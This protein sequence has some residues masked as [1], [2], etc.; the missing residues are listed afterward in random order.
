MFEKMF[1]PIKIKGLELKHRVVMPAM[2]T[3]FSGNDSYVTPQLIEYHKARVKGG[4]ALNIVEVSSVHTPSA[5]RHF[6]SISEDKYIP[7][8][9]QLT[10]AIHAEGGKAGIQLWQ[11]SLAVGMDQTAQILMASDMPMGP[12]ITLPGITEAQIYEIID[13]YGKAAKRAVEAGFDTVEFHCAHNYLPHSF[14]SGGINHR[15]DEWGGSLENRMKFPLACIKAIRENIPEDMPLFMRV[16]AHDDYLP[17]GMTIEDTIVF[18]N[19]AKEAG[20]DVLDVSRGNII[21]PA[22]K[23]EVPPIDL[24]PGFNIENA[25]HIRKETGM[26]TIGVGRINTPGLAEKYLSEDKVDMVVMGRA[27]LVDPEFL[28]KA[29]AGNLED[30]DY[31][32]GCDQGCLDGFADANCPHI[33]CLRNPAVGKEVELVLTPAKQQETVLITGAGIAGLEAAIVL[34]QRG[35]KAIVVEAS[36]KVGGQ[37]LTAGQAPRKA[38]MKAAVIAMGKKAEHLGAEIRLNTPFTKEVL[39]EVKPHT[40]FNA[41]GAKPIIPNIPGADKDFVVN[42]HDVL[43]GVSKVE[44]NI[45][46]IGGG[47]VGME[48]AE[49]LAERGCKVTDL[50]MMKE[51]CADMGM[52]RKFCVDEAIQTL[53]INAITEVTVTSI[54]DGKVIGTKAGETVEYPCDY[55]VMAIGS[56]SNDGSAIEAA[57]REVGCGYITIGDA[58]MARRALNAVAEAYNAARTFDDPAIYAKT[59]KPRKVIAVTGVTGTMGKETIKNLLARPYQYHVK[60]FARPSEVNRG[61]MKAMADPNLEVIWGD[62]ANYEDIKRLVDGA[63]YV[64]HIGAMVSPAA[65]K[66]PEKTL[67]TNI[68]STLSII[69]AIKEQ[70]DPDKVHFVYIGT[71]AETGAR[72]YPIHWGRVGDPINPSIFDYYAL[73]KVYS[74]MAVF[75]SGLK[76]WVSIRQTGQHPSAEGAGEEPIIFHQPVNNVLEWSTSIESGICMANICEDWVPESFWRK[77]YNLSSGPDYRLTCWELTGMMMEP[78]GLS[79]KDLY[80]PEVMPLYNFHGHYYT[81]SKDLDDILHF[82]C[83]PGQYYWAGVKNEMERMAANPM[84]RAMFPTGEQMKYH[85]KEIGARKGGYY[86]ALE[87]KDEDWMNAFFGSK[88][89]RPD[90]KSWDDVEL[91]HPAGEPTYLDHGYDESKGLEN[92]TVEDLQKAAAFRGGEYLETEVPADI[93]TPVTW[94]CHDGHVFKLS[95]NAVLQGGHWCPECIAET[96]HYGDIAK[97]NPFYAQVWTPLHGDNDNYVIGMEFSGLKVANELK[98]K[99][100]L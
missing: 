15:T 12:D 19:K 71:V 79:I 56:R 22:N 54:E 36:D 60:A 99:L 2:G 33:T 72:T 34:Q 66:Y 69:K 35:H 47:M 61:K 87:N 28:N 59:S 20:V 16:D 21:T 6:L 78:F 55:A 82:R 98:E 70:P 42:S 94:K 49:Y 77:A 38:E 57:C 100:G 14:L 64:L 50:E 40:V 10:D 76:H 63:D 37:F 48:V 1:S 68:G 24:A 27:Q 97:K 30:I 32:V 25:A 89:N 85:N 93:Y 91:F 52:A 9:K 96:W 5:P 73:S 51:Y 86:Y 29:K 90:I 92:L 81:D 53:G 7:G 83:I 45:V 13:C 88:E 46:I 43:N 3:K 18:C 95:V 17:G 11:G 31:C 44:G 65:D 39:E 23:F 84:I 8:L 67:Y 74:E 75:D 26:I 41:I 4:S 58:G 62:L 80:D